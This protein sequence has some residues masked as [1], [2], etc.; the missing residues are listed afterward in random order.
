MGNYGNNSS[1]GNFWLQPNAY[2][3]YF[4]LW[5]ERF[6]SFLK[7]ITVVYSRLPPNTHEF[8]FLLLVNYVGLVV[9]FK[10]FNKIFSSLCP[11][12]TAASHD[13]LV[14]VTFLGYWFFGPCFDCLRVILIYLIHWIL[15][16][17]DGIS[18]W[19]SIRKIV[20]TGFPCT[21]CG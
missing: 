7:S 9:Q 2:T 11:A 15:E 19:G 13:V 16:W 6:D 3:I 12:W 5:E 10:L 4:F 17:R 8:L 20:V 1:L 21:K 14:G 18:P